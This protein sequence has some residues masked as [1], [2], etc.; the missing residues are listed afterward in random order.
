[1]LTV[2][3]SSFTPWQKVFHYQVPTLGLPGLSQKNPKLSMWVF[4]HLSPW[5]KCIWSFNKKIRK[6]TKILLKRD[7]E[8]KPRLITR[9]RLFW[10][11]Q[12]TN[13]S[14][15]CLIKSN[16]VWNNKNYSIVLWFISTF[17]HFLGDLA[18]KADKKCNI[19]LSS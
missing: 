19:S 7:Q 15:Y 6:D 17:H 13:S 4:L 12:A 9:Y 11:G 2:F 1:M 5:S 8:P 18:N 16:I 10:E 3:T 14:V